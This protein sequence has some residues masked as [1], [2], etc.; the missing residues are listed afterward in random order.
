VIV[1]DTS[2]VVAIF[3]EEP[4]RARLLTALTRASARSLSAGNYLECAMVLDRRAGGRAD[5]D[6]WLYDRTVTIVP[7]DLA[8]AQRA[9]D[10][11]VRFGKGRHPAALNYGDCFAYA[12]ARSLEAPL[13]F[14]GEDFARTDIVQA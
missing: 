14:K 2:A 6:Q 12:L 8:L 13:L 5:L 7:V 3:R 11:F 4:E 10:A 1:V 9:A